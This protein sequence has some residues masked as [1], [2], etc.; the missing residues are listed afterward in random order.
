[1][2]IEI[3]VPTSLNEITLGQYQKY[4]KITENNP[5]GN[6]LDAKMI[7]N[8]VHTFTPE[9]NHGNNLYY[10]TP[11]ALKNGLTRF[12]T[13]YIKNRQAISKLKGCSPFQLLCNFI[14]VIHANA[15]ILYTQRWQVLKQRSHQY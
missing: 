4:L 3:N 1:M 2:K 14:V 7:K 8:V 15:Y 12:I 9:A 13:M 5:E 6:F 11:I 10:S